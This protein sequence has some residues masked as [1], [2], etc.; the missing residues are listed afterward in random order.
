MK[1]PK[2]PAHDFPE[3]GSFIEICFANHKPVK[4]TVIR[5]SRLVINLDNNMTV[6]WHSIHW[7]K[8]AVPDEDYRTVTL[9]LTNEEEE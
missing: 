4:A 5:H 3:V 8:P 1:K 9:E 6:P 2:V 7:W